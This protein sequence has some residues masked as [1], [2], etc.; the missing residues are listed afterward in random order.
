MRTIREPAS[1]RTFTE[2]ARRA[3][4]VDA[5]IETIAELGYAGTSFAQIAKRAKLSSKG[6]ISYHFAGKDELVQEIVQE[7]FTDIAQFMANRVAPQPT[8]TAALRAYIEGNIE[9]AG[10][11][12]ARMKALLDIF[13]NGALH[14]DAETER[15][16]VS[17]LEQ[18]LR[19]G[20]DSGEF[21]TFDVQVMATAIQ[22]AV[23]GP[24]FLLAG[25]PDLDL[26]S[27]ARE[28]VTLF[29]LATRKLP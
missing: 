27:Y 29:D 10:A 28:L 2:T 25:D 3:Q 17:P 4:I 16:T 8:A 22:R 24:I 20:Q 13:M 11:R 9:F 23:E 7:I 19:R 5:A 15:T 12:R 21:R 14:Y 18:I 26:G 1:E 6:L